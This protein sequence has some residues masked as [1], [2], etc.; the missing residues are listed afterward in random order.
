MEGK[1]IFAKP[2]KDVIRQRIS[3][4]TYESKSLENNLKR[5]LEDYL[6]NLKGPFDS[7]VRY[8][9][10]E[11]EDYET[12]GVKL[13]TYGIIKGANSF[14]ACAVKNEKESLLQLGYE[15]EE[16]IL[17]ATSLG[18]GTCW[19]GGAFNKGEFSKALGLK[20]D[21]ILP[22]VTPIGYPKEKEGL[23]GSLMRT[24]AGSKN[25][26]NFEDIFYDGNFDRKLS[27]DSAGI[28]KEALEMVRLAPS[29]S[30][31]QPW[32]IVKEGDNLHIYLCH[33]KGYSK[34]A[35]F[36]MQ[37]IDIGIAMCHLD[38]ALKEAGYE[39]S[40]KNLKPSIRP[41]DEDTEYVISW[42]NSR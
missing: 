27:G 5:S 15:L 6:K 41:L 30:N 20:E 3:V 40:F 28:Y 24:F 1:R 17:Y 4:R 14:V 29:A 31:K 39:G 9:F 37:V 19:L 38:L 12:Q 13:G 18:I 23:V 10:M 34:G 8:K 7:K 42:E 22:I 25:R 11:I 2:M 33:T 35:P 26:K 36:D 21:E 16:F 32:R